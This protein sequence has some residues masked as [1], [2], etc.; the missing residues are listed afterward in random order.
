MLFLYVA[1]EPFFYFYML[2]QVER[3]MCAVSWL[4]VDDFFSPFKCIGKGY[5]CKLF[6]GD[7]FHTQRNK[8]E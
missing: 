7:I 1:I 3:V 4:M 5:R 8:A 2:L 6:I